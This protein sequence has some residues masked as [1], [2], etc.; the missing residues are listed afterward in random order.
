MKTLLTFVTAVFLFMPSV[1]AQ[2]VVY[3]E[4]FEGTPGVTT[5][6]TQLWSLNTTLYNTGTKSYSAHIITAGDTSLLTTTSFSTIGH[7]FVLLEFS[8]ICKIEFFDAG[9]IHVSNDNG[10]TWTQLTETHYLGTSGFSAATGN[11]FTA[12]AYTDWLPGNPTPPSNAWWKHE[13]FDISALAANATQVMVR[14]ELRDMNNGT[15]F[16]NWGW[17]VDDIKV[18]GAISELTP[19]T[20]TL[21]API[22]QDTAYTT[23]PYDIYADITDASGVAIARLVY[24]LNGG[25]K[26]TLVMV[27]TT[28]NT[29]Y[30]EIPSFT[31][32]NTVNYYV[33]AV[34]SSVSANHGQTQVYSFFIKKSLGSGQNVALTA[35]AAHSGG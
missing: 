31:Y 9:T 8:H 28:G 16:E 7:S 29:Y 10:A 30:A 6:G 5:A 20:I 26:D 34:D 2:T 14:F 19:P 4:G 22:L 23:G 12:T 25:A 32:N 18:T 33:Y 27:N 17:V 21:Q 13:I 3:Q 1:F 11:K 24:D 35:V 15:Q